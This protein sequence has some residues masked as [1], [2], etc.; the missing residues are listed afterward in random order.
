MTT[1]NVNDFWDQ[2]T[3][4]AE[5]RYDLTHTQVVA[6]SDGGSGYGEERFKEAF[7]GSRQPLF[8]QLDD[9]HVAQALTRALHGDK[10]WLKAAKKAVRDKQEETLVTIL[11]TYE[12][13]LEND[14]QIQ[15]VADVKKYLMNHWS[16]LFDWRD[17]DKQ[18][19]KIAGKLGAMESNQRHHVTFRMKKRGMH[20]GGSVEAMVKVIQGCQN[21][22]LQAA[23]LASLEL[24]ERA[25]RRVTKTMRIATLLRSQTRP[26]IGVHLGRIA[27]YTSA[28]SSVGHLNKILTL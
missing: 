28:S 20:W 23:Y 26:S 2:A 14:K 21:G 9:F 4:V 1:K 16:R 12:S 11:D 24:G 17:K 13:Q 19:P 5:S 22:T 15:K 27:G 8:V 7:S 18:A 6:N 3:A 10:D 25:M